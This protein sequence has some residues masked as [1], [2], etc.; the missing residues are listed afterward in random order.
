MFDDGIAR[1]IHIQFENGAPTVISAVA[2]RAKKN[3]PGQ[4]QPR[5]G[6]RAVKVIKTLK[7]RIA[8]AIGINLEDCAIIGSA[9]G[10][11]CAIEDVSAEKERS[12]RESAIGIVR[13]PFQN[14][15]ACAV[16]AYFENGSSD[17]PITIERNP[18]QK[19]LN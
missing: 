15:E 18:I 10:I 1:A 16:R 6:I 11:S 12:F 13:K 3:S 7:D 5:L 8:G 2:S 17:R 14:G 4:S 19:T 9:A